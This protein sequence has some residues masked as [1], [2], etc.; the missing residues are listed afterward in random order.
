MLMESLIKFYGGEVQQKLYSD[1][2]HVVQVGLN[3]K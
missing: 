3:E 2:D 1:V